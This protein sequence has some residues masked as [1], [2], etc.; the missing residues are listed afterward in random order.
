MATKK[1]KPA[2]KQRTTEKARAL[3]ERAFG[4]DRPAPAADVAVVR[5]TRGGTVHGLRRDWR[6][7]PGLD[8]AKRS[9][10]PKI[11]ARLA[12]NAVIQQKQFGRWIP[13][14]VEMLRSAGEADPERFLAG[15][16][17]DVA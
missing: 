11:R 4:N 10:W 3:V 2:A 7:I 5:F 1:R 8:G 17:E 14:T 9:T 6:I 16:R 13:V 15:L 12:P